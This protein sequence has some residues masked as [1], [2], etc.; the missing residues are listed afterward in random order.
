MV[1]QATGVHMGEAFEMIRRHAR[2]RNRR[3]ANVAA[4]VTAGDLGIETLSR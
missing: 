2:S 1:A 4:A 3:V